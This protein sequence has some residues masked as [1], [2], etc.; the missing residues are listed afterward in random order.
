M[1]VVLLESLIATLSR[2]F[3]TRCTVLA[4]MAFSLKHEVSDGGR[5]NIYVQPRHLYSSRSSKA[6]IMASTR[7]GS[8]QVERQKT[9]TPVNSQAAYVAAASNPT[10]PG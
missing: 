8:Q 9:S 4:C 5:I 1:R 10:R 3:H 6:V 2:L 7:N